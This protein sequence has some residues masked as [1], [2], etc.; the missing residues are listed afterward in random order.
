MEKMLVLPNPIGT[1]ARV[2]MHI[3]NVR[4]KLIFIAQTLFGKPGNL[5]DV[6]FVVLCKN[7]RNVSKFFCH[8][9]K[10]FLS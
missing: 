2:T 8:S 9:R 7:N 5:V 6:V 4:P 1:V 3:T 10:T